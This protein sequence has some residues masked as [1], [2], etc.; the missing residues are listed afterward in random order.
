MR[1]S[2]L[3]TYLGLGH[4]E[5]NVGIIAVTICLEITIQGV[6]TPSPSSARASTSIRGFESGNPRTGV[7]GGTYFSKHGQAIC[8]QFQSAC[9]PKQYVSCLLV[10]TIP[11]LSESFLKSLSKKFKLPVLEAAS[12]SSYPN[13][14][15]VVSRSQTTGT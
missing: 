8:F 11:T 3:H 6:N 1:T 9:F 10:C 12:P 2:Y 4:L 14:P 5:H 7:M 13:Q 15:D